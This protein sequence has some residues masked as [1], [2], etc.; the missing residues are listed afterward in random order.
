M[1]IER[2]GTLGHYR[3]VEKIG[4]G[5]MGVVWKAFDLTLGREVAL[6]VLPDALARDAHRVSRLEREAKALAALNH[7]NIVTV[8]SIEREDDVRFL[9]MELVR[10]RRLSSLIPRGGLPL[11][12]I[13]DVTIPI[14]SALVAAHA[15]GVVHR[16]L[17]PSNVMVTD[18]GQVKVLDFGLAKL[19]DTESAAGADERTYTATA[20]G[21][22]VGTTGY[23]SPEQ[24]QGKTVDGRSDIFSLGAVLYEMTTGERAF[25]GETTA[26]TLGAILRDTPPS[27]TRFRPE[28]PDGLRRLVKRCLE[29]DL[30]RRYQTALDVRNELVELR[31]ELGTEPLQVE[32]PKQLPTVSLPHRRLVPIAAGLLAV[33]LVAVALGLGPLRQRFWKPPA[34]GIRSLAVLPLANQMGDSGQDYFVDGMHDALITELARLGTLKVISRT[35]VMRYRKPDRPIRDIARDL[36]V[37]GIVEGS[38]LRVGDRL[39][40]TAQLI[41]AQTDAHVWADAY[42]RDLADAMAMIGDVTRAIATQIDVTLTARQRARIGSARRASPEAQ[43]FYLRGRQQLS[44]FL[45]DTIAR[46]AALFQEAID[47][48][49]DYAAPH[50]ALAIC[51][52][53]PGMFGFAMPH[54]VAAKTREAAAKAIALDE[55]LAEAH[56]ALALVKYIY[57]WDWEGGMRESRRA[58]ELDPSNWIA[59]RAV[60]DYQLVMGDLDGAVTTARRGREVDPLSFVMDAS[61][62][63]RL[64][65]ARHFDE[66]LVEARR[67]WQKHGAKADRNVVAIGHTEMAYSLWVSGHREEALSQFRLLWADDRELVTALDDAARRGGPTAGLQAAAAV[68]ASR[69]ERGE[70]RRFDVIAEYFAMAGNADAAILWLERAYAEHSLDV[71]QVGVDPAFDPIRGDPRFVD[72][73]RRLKLPS[74]RQPQT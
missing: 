45:P 56:L 6:K 61:V 8:H 50:A 2:G 9:A 41:D 55:D 30:S 16:D 35:S 73:V 38:V 4:Q 51:Y 39:R 32:V 62:V 52:V 69:A 28:L 53:Y 59:Y 58:L 66:A 17:K 15:R 36:G 72:V 21:E 68:L 48:D 64:A 19:A 54:D 70:N 44:A 29:K 67:Y 34:A 25:K 43:D 14:A 42:E 24:V 71:P 13:L 22:I 7:P 49:P 3:L 20:A 63:S 27:I 60:S 33:V 5:G 26:S 40:I 37:E 10:G 18:D 46:A 1:A 65:T 74:P 23:M 12:R 57:D 11:D 47:I 31:S